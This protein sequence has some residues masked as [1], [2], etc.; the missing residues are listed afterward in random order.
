AMQAGATDYITKPFEEARIRLAIDK[1]LSTRE[2]LLENRNL[3]T[4]L[5]NRFAFDA[6]IAED[7]RMLRV[8]DLARQVATA[9][10]TVIVYGESGTGKELVTRAIHE[11][12]PRS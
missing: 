9:N 4:E 11:A 7:P 8:L 10:T 3:R 5:R 12:S 2:L 1:A 6:I